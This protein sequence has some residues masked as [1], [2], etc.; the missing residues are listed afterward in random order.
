MDSLCLPKQEVSEGRMAKVS[1]FKKNVANLCSYRDNLG[2]LTIGKQGGK[3]FAAHFFL[4]GMDYV[5]HTS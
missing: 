4:K 2:G 1:I 5:L 3:S